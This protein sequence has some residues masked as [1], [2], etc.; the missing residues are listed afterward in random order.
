MARASY[1]IAMLTTATIVLAALL[2]DVVDSVVQHCY[3]YRSAK[4]LWRFVLPTLCY[5]AVI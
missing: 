1:K 3:P 4:Q 5:Y 2:H